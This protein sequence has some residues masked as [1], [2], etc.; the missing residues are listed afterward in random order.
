[1]IGLAALT[2]LVFSVFAHAIRSLFSRPDGMPATMRWMANLGA[3]GA[4]A[5]V[6]TIATRDSSSDGRTAVAVVIYLL[7]LA[8][9]SWARETIRHHPLPI[10][11]STSQPALVVTTGPY[12]LMRHPFYVSY[13]LAWFAGVVG[14]PSAW[15][16]LP[17]VVMSC[18]YVVA[19]R[20]EE[21]ALLTGSHA[22]GYQR[23]LEGSDDLQT[24][25]R[26]EIRRE[27][28]CP[29]AD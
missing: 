2:A 21:R 9:F 14:A 4:L 6:V 12:A 3:L 8:L 7:A 25:S 19:A 11:F 5:H 10:A 18:F 24:H 16:V 20:S 13:T 29:P 28:D 17:A 26:G 23:Y 1:M 15:T 27:H 22:D